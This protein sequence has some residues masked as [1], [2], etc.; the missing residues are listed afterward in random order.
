MACLLPSHVE[1]QLLQI[2]DFL[3]RY[4]HLPLTV[5]FA[6]LFS[7]LSLHQLV[8]MAKVQIAIHD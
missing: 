7:L 2:E 3:I 4:E 5:F 1:G 6:I 8:R